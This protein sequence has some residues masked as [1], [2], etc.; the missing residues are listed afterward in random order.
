MGRY[1]VGLQVLVPVVPDVG[2][3]GQDI[4]PAV[5][6]FDGLGQMHVPG[7][8]VFV[9]QDDVA[10]RRIGGLFEVLGFQA[11]EDGAGQDDDPHVF[12]FARANAEI[13][14]AG[15]EVKLPAEGGPA[16]APMRRFR[17]AGRNPPVEPPVG[18]PVPG[19]EQALFIGVLAV[20]SLGEVD[21]Q[22][23]PQFRPQGPR[24]GQ[25]R[26]QA[27]NAVGLEIE[28]QAVEPLRQAQGPAVDHVAPDQDLGH[29]R[30]VR[31]VLQREPVQGDVSAQK[32]ARGGGGQRGRMGG[33]SVH[34]GASP[35]IFE[36]TNLYRP[37][38]AC[39][40]LCSA[41]SRTRS[42]AGG[43]SYTVSGE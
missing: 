28:P 36:R 40:G 9:V 22:R 41:V 31:Q 19:P 32:P 4:P 18:E 37:S 8:A 14:V 17:L 38:M 2:V 12:K 39:S 10:A 6:E 30:R 11:I 26:V 1:G 42:G 35:A 20:A 24:P 25:D 34:A 27:G 16:V 43:G 33:A 7:K 21:G 5:V 3:P 29:G 23:H 15:M 13:G